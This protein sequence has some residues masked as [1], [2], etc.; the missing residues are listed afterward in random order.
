MK[1]LLVVLLM[2]G[3]IYTALTLATDAAPHNRVK[4]VDM[5]IRKDQ[6]CGVVV[7]ITYPD[8][9]QEY[10]ELPKQLCVLTEA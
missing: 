10:Y 4:G 6:Q 5:M 7:R 2:I 1:A 9:Y 3:A 8:D